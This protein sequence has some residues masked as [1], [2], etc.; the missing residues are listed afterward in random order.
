MN[1]PKRC[2]YT[3]KCLSTLSKVSALLPMGLVGVPQP[4]PIPPRDHQES[5]VFP[6]TAPKVAAL[7]DDVTNSVARTEL[8]F[9][10]LLLT[11]LHWA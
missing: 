8:E 6:G 1:T 4:V 9:C 3:V 10:P 7:T 11:G 5:N 2:F